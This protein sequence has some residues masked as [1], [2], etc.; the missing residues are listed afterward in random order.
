VEIT[1]LLPNPCW[2]AEISMWY[3]GDG[4]VYLKDPEEAQV[5][6]KEYVDVNMGNPALCPQV[7][8]PWWGKINIVDDYHDKLSVYINQQIEDTVE[9]QELKAKQEKYVVIKPVWD[10]QAPPRYCAMVPENSVYPMIY[11]EVTNPMTKDE[12][13]NH[14]KKKYQNTDT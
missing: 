8:F 11:T 9:I 7:V 2:K 1:G 3:P 4:I 14:I 13:E 5:F 10:K 6:I 12:C